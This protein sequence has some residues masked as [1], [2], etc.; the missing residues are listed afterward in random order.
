M[1][2]TIP[3]GTLR[4]LLTSISYRAKARK[5]VRRKPPMVPHR[6]PR[7]CCWTAPP[8]GWC[9]ADR[10]QIASRRADPVQVETLTLCRCAGSVLLTACQHLLAIHPAGLAW[11]AIC[12]TVWHGSITGAHPCTPYI[13]YYNRRPV[14]ICAASGV[15]L[16][17]GMCWRC[18]GA[19]MRSSVAQVVL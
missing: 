9:R 11:S 6:P 16:V 18:C 8:G 2:A 13:H 14:L 7:S 10:G 3:A 17:S 5:E 19:V 4:L 12:C 15:A 1:A